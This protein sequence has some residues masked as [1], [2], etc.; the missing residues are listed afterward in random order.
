MKGIG[1][2][3]GGGFRGGRGRGGRQGGISHRGQPR[4]HDGDEVLGAA[5]QRLEGWGGE[6]EGGLCKEEDEDE[7]EEEE[8]LGV[9]DLT[10]TR[11]S[12]I[13]IDRRI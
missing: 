6:G 1:K 9:G 13:T 2:G 12:W 4:S 10:S 8:G 7:E 5:V 11:H 3:E